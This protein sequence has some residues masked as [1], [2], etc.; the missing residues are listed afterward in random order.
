MN[1]KKIIN[2]CII[3]VIVNMTSVMPIFCAEADSQ[4]PVSASQAGTAIHVN[5]PKEDLSKIYRRGDIRKY[6]RKD[7]EEVFVFDDILTSGPG[8]TITVYLVDGKVSSWDKNIVTFPVDEGSR[9]AIRNDITKEE[10]LKIYPIG[11]LKLYTRNGNKEVGTFYDI[12]TSDSDAT[13]TFYLVDGKVKSWERNKMIFPTKEDLHKIFPVE[14]RKAYV[15]S[16]TTEAET[17]DN[18]LSADPGDTITFYLVDS[19]VS[20]WDIN[21]EASIDRVRLIDETMAGARSKVKSEADER[22]KKANAAAAERLKAKS[23]ADAISKAEA[24]ADFKEIIAKANADA[25]ARIKAMEERSRYNNEI[26]S[27]Y[28]KEDD[29]IKTKQQTRASNVRDH[30]W[31]YNGGLYYR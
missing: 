24:E 15:S 26:Q 3:M 27:P 16:G 21:T 9:S 12:L 28:A 13:I 8:D 31:H 2:I 29:I 22:S 14:K 10:L 1:T 20:S 25:D 19:R 7:N 30:N 17:Y 6:E 23:D 11:N 4:A 18:I 5:M